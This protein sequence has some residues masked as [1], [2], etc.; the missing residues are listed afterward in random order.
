M[1]EEHGGAV[2]GF[3]IK[4]FADVVSDDDKINRTFCKA[5]GDEVFSG[6][7]GGGPEYDPF[8]GPSYK[9]MYH[10]HKKRAS[11]PHDPR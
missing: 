11:G 8:P 3:G 5:C 4:S 7:C 9:I 6:R 10:H 2:G 1:A